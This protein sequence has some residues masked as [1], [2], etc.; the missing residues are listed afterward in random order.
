MKSIT[1]ALFATHTFLIQWKLCHEKNMTMPCTL[2]WNSYAW[3]TNLCMWNHRKFRR[4]CHCNIRMEL[5]H[6]SPSSYRKLHLH[7]S[8]YLGS[9]VIPCKVALSLQSSSSPATLQGQ[10]TYFYLS[11]ISGKQCSSRGVRHINQSIKLQ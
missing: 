7:E 10:A 2:D 4:V 6:S 8:F 9:Q 11:I 3:S 1:G 5:I